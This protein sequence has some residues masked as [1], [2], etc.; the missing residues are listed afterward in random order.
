MCA[1][2]AEVPFRPLLVEEARIEAL[3]H[4][5]RRRFGA[6]MSHEAVRVVTSVEPAFLDSAFTSISARCG[7]VDRYLAEVLLLSPSARAAMVSNLV[8]G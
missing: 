3:R 4:D 5:L 8:V 2:Y 6:Q 7:S 1:R